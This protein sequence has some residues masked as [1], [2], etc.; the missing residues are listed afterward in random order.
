MLEHRCE[1]NVEC[2]KKHTHVSGL[3]SGA[4]SPSIRTKILSR[5]TKYFQSLLAS[6]CPE[7][8]VVANIAGRD[9]SST[10]GINLNK[11]QEETGLNP[12]VA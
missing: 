12:W 10:T 9:C 4:R 8:A 5:Y 6:D 7:V 3:S 2:S 1:T 11:L